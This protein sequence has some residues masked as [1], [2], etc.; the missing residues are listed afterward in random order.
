[1]III[2]YNNKLICDWFC[3]NPPVTYIDKKVILNTLFNSSKCNIMRRPKAGCMEACKLPQ[4]YSYFKS[5][6]LPTP[7]FTTDYES[8]SLPLCVYVA[9]F[10]KSCYMYYYSAL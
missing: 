5:I 1:M 10:S 9:G 6:R 4:I 7:Q 8:H 2:I 3:D